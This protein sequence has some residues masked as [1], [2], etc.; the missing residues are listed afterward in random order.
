MNMHIGWAIFYGI[1]IALIGFVIGTWVGA[2]TACIHHCLNAGNDD[3]EWDRAAR[4][5]VCM[6][7]AEDAPP[8]DAQTSEGP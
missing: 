2:D 1:M 4:K 6:R 7:I 5:C 8:A 3:G